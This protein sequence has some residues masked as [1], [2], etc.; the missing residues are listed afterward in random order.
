MKI[1][2]WVQM[3]AG[4]GTCK[5]VLKGS[6]FHFSLMTNRICEMQK[7]RGIFEKLVQVGKYN[8]EKN[9]DDEK[10]CINGSAMN[11]ENFK[12]YSEYIKKD[13]DMLKKKLRDAKEN[14]FKG[15]YEEHLFDCIQNNDYKDLIIADVIYEKEKNVLCIGEG[16]L[17]FSTLIQ[18][19]LSSCK[20]VATSMENEKTLKKN[21]GNVFSKNLKIL[22]SHGGIYVPE[23]NVETI[24][25]QFPENTFDVIIFNFP[26]VLPSND[27]IQSK[28]KIQ[29]DKLMDDKTSYMKYYKKSEYFLL[30][31]LFYWL[32]KNSSIL[33]KHNGFLHV[34]VN[35]KYLT[36]DFSNTFSLSLVQKIDFS[37]SYM[38]YKSLRYI[39]SMMYNSSSFRND[40]SSSSSNSNSK[41]NVMFTSHGKIFK[42][43]KMAHTSTLIFQKGTP[44]PKDD[45]R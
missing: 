3:C 32:F 38:V 19:N 25:E 23:I 42:T 10:D 37:N 41:K 33:L 36:C 30:N 11:K 34:R 16:N 44:P 12:K 27:F 35:D 29:I 40:S 39:P 21:F 14:Y 43:F 6:R 45:H 7:D 26:F 22:E 15:S 28:W 8:V 20:V 5:P 4:R 9:G 24:Y 13:Y 1:W 18:K 31:K 17:S 2:W